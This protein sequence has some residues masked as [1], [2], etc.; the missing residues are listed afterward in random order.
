MV[1]TVALIL[2]FLD[3]LYNVGHATM[4]M[5]TNSWSFAHILTIRDVWENCIEQLSSRV[6][7]FSFDA[8]LPQL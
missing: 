2:L 1:Q 5:E 4:D 6:K 7:N 8:R 3:T